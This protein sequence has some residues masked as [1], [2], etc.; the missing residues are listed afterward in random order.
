MGIGLRE[1]AAVIVA[2]PDLIVSVSTE[3]LAI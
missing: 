3:N 2:H 1:T